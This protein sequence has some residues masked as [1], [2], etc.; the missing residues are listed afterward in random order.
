METHPNLIPLPRAEALDAVAQDTLRAL[1]A[2]LKLHLFQTPLKVP[3]DPYKGRAPR[4]STWLKTSTA[5]V[6]GEP[7]TGSEGSAP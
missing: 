5:S 2:L 7:T 4:A 3:D 1:R 6:R